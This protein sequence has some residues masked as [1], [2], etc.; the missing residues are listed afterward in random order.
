MLARPAFKELAGTR[1]VGHIG[2]GF[3]PLPDD[4]S[5]AEL[6]RI[7]LA[8]AGDT[9]HIVGTCK[10]GN[11]D[12]PW[13]VV[14]PSGRLVGLDGLRVIDASIVP[15]CPRANTALTTIM[16]AEKLAAEIG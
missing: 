5:D 16:L 2:V 3:G 9:Q 8:T 13:T 11:P 6:D 7:A 10:M 15:A 4:P 12:D 1:L 14:D